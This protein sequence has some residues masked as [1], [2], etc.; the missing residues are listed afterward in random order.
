MV[1]HNTG[2]YNLNGSGAYPDVGLTAHTGKPA[3]MGAFRAPTLR[4]VDRTVYA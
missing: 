1:F 4:N 2:L 3:D